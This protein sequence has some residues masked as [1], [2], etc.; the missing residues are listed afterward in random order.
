[1][2]DQKTA[3]GKEKLSFDRRDGVK[4]YTILSL[5]G[6]LDM[7][8]LPLA[9]ERINGLVNEGKVKIILDLERMNYIDSSGLGFFIGT[10]KKLRDAGGDLILVNL[11]AYIYGIFKLIQL[12]H[13]I[14]TYDSLEE[15]EK[16]L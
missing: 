6:D 3:G 11:N 14:K 15:A 4:G 7:W 5:I 13:I 9:K 8:T 1:M 2:A 16:E 12:Q 10:L